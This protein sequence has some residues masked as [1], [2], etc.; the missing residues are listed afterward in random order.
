MLGAQIHEAGE[1]A[2]P[3]HGQIEQDEIH[4]VIIT[5]LLR[6]GVEI[7]AFDDGAA[8]DSA[9]NGLTQGAANQRVVVGYNNPGRS[10]HDKSS[11]QRCSY[12]R[13]LLQSCQLPYS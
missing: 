11:P 2:N 8:G 6:Q 9:R 5:Q 10:A 13:T 3:G 4:L 7:G 1:A 12:W